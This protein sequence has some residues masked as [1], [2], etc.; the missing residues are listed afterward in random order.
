MGV[1]PLE[2]SLITSRALHRNHGLPHHQLRSDKSNSRRTIRIMVPP[3]SCT[4]AQPVAAIVLRQ[5]DD[6]HGVGPG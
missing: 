1:D 4:Q 2:A 5:I 6:D 3:K